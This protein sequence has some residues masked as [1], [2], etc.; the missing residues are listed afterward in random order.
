MA[1][2]PDTGPGID[3]QDP[4]VANSFSLELQ[5]LEAAWFT[6]VDGFENENEVV[7][8]Y[9]T[10]KSGKQIVTKVPGSTKW[11]DLQLKR[12]LTADDLLFKW[13]Q[14]VLDGDLKTARKDGS[15][16]G[17]SAKGEIVIQYTFTRGWISKWKGA[18]FSTS[19]NQ[20]ALEEVTI[21]HEGLKRVK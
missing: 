17:Y 2:A 20:A 3:T 5:G 21:T 19:N 12:G 11:A 10:D 15:I 13:R 8:L 14:M 6:E 1:A 7:S 16:T 18:G 9:Q 4:I